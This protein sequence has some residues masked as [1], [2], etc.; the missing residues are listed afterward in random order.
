MF[1]YRARQAAL[2][3]ILLFSTIPTAKAQPFHFEQGYLE[4][5]KSHSEVS[6]GKSATTPGQTFRVFHLEFAD[7]ASATAFQPKFSSVFHRSGRFV[8]IFAQPT[9]QA[10]E[11]IAAAPKLSWLDYNRSVAVPSPPQ[12]KP[13]QATRARSEAV[14]RNGLEGFTGKGVMLAVVDTGF[15]VRHPDFQK[16][17]PD[18]KLVSRFSAIWDTTETR[19]GFGT[20]APFKYPG[21]QPI[22]VIYSRDDIN[23][24]L[25]KP[26]KER[27][28]IVW[29]RDGHGTA[30]AGIAAGNGRA[31]TDGRYAGVASEAEL[32]GVRLGDQS[33]NTY[34][35]PAI[36]EW[37]DSKA[38]TRPLVISNSWGGHRSGHDGSTIVERQM[39]ERF[40]EQRP[41][42]LVLFAAGNEGQDRIHASGDYAGPDR[43]GLLK[44][45]KVTQDDEV[46]VSVYFDSADAGLVVVPKIETSSY[47]HGVT[48]Q[49][50]WRFAVTP[51]LDQVQIS[52]ASG[53]PGH[54]DAYIS[55][56]IGE[57]AAAFD[58][59]VA[60]FEELVCYPGNAQNVLSVGSYDFNP[61]FEKDGRNLQLGVEVP[62][63][64]EMAAMT[65]GDVSGYSSPG[66]TRLGRLK[67]D[68]S[69]PGQWWTAAGSADVENKTLFET[70]GRYTLFNGT[71]AATPY[72]AGV[73]AL[74]LEKNP[75]L[76]LAQVRALLDKHLKEDT[77]TGTLPNATWG[78][79][80]LTL[81]A[82]KAILEDV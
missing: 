32:I 62:D 81:P 13:V 21:G 8:D 18:G 53:K 55:G 36:L 38:G 33:L 17:G 5:V 64:D 49:T 7:G 15:D 56:Q 63:S 71:S 58:R 45:P 6:A 42:R 26:E 19:S 28:E 37:L 73:M 59:G 74:L 35:L 25:A 76:T 65:V 52:S 48:G 40:T 10:L 80:K 31:L 27:P 34:L 14:V 43:P 12:A 69:A 3:G 9:D 44:F 2:V 51:G 66:L 22:G 79:G 82:I 68:F 46:E 67:P 29:D 78:R 77:Y 60:T 41:G 57:K 16:V 75:T 30:C 72:S 11:E 61:F 39:D 50:V 70:S 23:A 47:K 20:A 4:T 54:F 1:K 24:Y